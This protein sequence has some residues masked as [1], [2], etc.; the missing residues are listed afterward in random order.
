MVVL[1]RSTATYYTRSDVVPVPVR[2]LAPNQVCLAWETFR[3]D[4]LIREYAH[5]ARTAEN[6]G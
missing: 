6:S 4:A 2:D 5:I 1:P 3:N